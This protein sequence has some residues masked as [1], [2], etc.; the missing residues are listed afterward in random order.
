MASG[1]HAEPLVRDRRGDGHPGAPGPKACSSRWVALRRSSL[2]VKDNRLHYVNNFVGAEEQRSSAPR[3][4]R[5]ARPDSLGVI[6]EG[7]QE[8]TTR[9]GLCPCTMASQGGEGRSRPS[10]AR[11]PSRAQACSS[12]GRSA[13][14]SP[15]TTRASPPL[16]PAAVIKPGSRS[17]S[18]ASRTWTSSAKPPHAHLRE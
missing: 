11:S 3:T 7:R 1:Q 18:A 5:S 12:D 17:T 16:F 9:P 13:S 15:T 4:F 6:R 8:P 14:R 10:W 2:Y